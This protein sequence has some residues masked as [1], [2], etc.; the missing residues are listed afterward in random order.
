[1]D[2]IKTKLKVGDQVI[3]ISGKSKGQQGKISEIDR[4]K[5]RAIV[6]GINLI[7]KTVKKSKDNQQGGIIT[8]E[9]PLQMS[10]LM[11]FDVA[12]GKGTRLGLRI[13]ADGKKV[14]FSK[15]SGQVIA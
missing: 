7:K 12:S 9:A 3:V 14:R 11:Y 1:M 15:K 4:V 10:K 8:R 5:G 13:E 2:T 6:E